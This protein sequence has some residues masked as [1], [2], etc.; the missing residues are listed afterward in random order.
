MEGQALEEMKGL[1]G[2]GKRAV[3]TRL[4]EQAVLR[5]EEHEGSR[6]FRTGA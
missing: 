5:A 3:L 1:S 2:E 6:Y 4:E